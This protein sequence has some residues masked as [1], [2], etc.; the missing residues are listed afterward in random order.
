M[1]LKNLLQPTGNVC[2]PT[3]LHELTYAELCKLQVT[4][5]SHFEDN[6]WFEY[7][8]TPGGAKSTSTINWSM[9]LHDDSRLTDPQH[10]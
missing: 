2:A 9:E 1:T 3:K 7:N 10:R 8:P 4:K 5:Y 6:K